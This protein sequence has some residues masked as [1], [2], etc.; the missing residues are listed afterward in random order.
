MQ[1]TGGRCAFS[2][3]IRQAAS[4]SVRAGPEPD[5]PTHSGRQ[6]SDGWWGDCR[7]R[8]TP[9]AVTDAAR[10]GRLN[11]SVSGNDAAKANQNDDRLGTGS[12]RLPVSGP[13]T[14]RPS[15]FQMLLVCSSR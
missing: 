12:R 5:T 6:L 15:M 14:A 10:Y 3:R 9:L 1:A 7:L 2:A 4:S 13:S 11:T 8:S